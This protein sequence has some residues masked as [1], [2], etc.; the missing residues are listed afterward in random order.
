MAKEIKKEISPLV[1]N[2]KEKTTLLI[3]KL[4]EDLKVYFADLK[5]RE[6]YF[7]KTGVDEA[8]AKL[9]QAMREIV[10]YEE[11]I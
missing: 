4:E 2:E 9:D 6:F 5:K 7:Y 11:K 1:S 10:V 3:K 8:K